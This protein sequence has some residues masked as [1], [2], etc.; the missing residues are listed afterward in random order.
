MGIN[1]LMAK[2]V[3]ITQFAKNNKEKKNNH[4]YTHKY[5]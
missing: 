1:K 4:A 2:S 3:K 5:V